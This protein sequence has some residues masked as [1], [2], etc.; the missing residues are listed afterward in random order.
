MR[1][2]KKIISMLLGLL[3]LGAITTLCGIFVVRNLVSGSTIIDLAVKS[4]ENSEDVYGAVLAD[5]TGE[6][7]F[8]D[9]NAYINEEELKD[10]LEDFITDTLKYYSG[11]NGVEV[12]STEVIKEQVYES[13]KKY[14]DTTGNTVNYEEI[15]G[16]FDKLDEEIA[17]SVKVT[18]NKEV[19]KVFNF[20]YSDRIV[21][22]LIGI[23]IGCIL[24]KF[25]LTG[26]VISLLK[27]IAI[28]AI[29]NS[30]GNLGFG[31]ALKSIFGHQNEEQVNLV[32]D[33][34]TSSFYKIA[35]ASVSIAVV[36]IVLL[37]IVKLVGKAR[38]KKKD[39]ILEQDTVIVENE[40]LEEKLENNVFIE[41][42]QDNSLE[43]KDL[44]N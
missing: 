12:P 34:F 25:L 3:L 6:K 7:V 36:F 18:E 29:L 35:I 4:V 16:A 15:Q 23:I 27:D 2:L 26:S 44:K 32:V 17:S 31:V 9:L 30:L 28:V 43:D 13:L 38:S 19:K 39:A 33:S 11:V 21:V 41:I 24:L 22:L 20:I 1:V 37:V 5:L 42:N 40:P 10:S 14:E 8:S